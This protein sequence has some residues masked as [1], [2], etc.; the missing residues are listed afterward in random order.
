MDQEVYVIICPAKT[1]SFLTKKGKFRITLGAR[2]SDFQMYSSDDAED[3]LFDLNKDL[4]EG[5]KPYIK[6]HIEATHL[7]H[8]RP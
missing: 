7:P 2:K 3:L 4:P 6:K 1:S 8:L 5:K